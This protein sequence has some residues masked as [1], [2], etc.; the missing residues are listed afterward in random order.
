VRRLLA[1]SALGTLLV[2]LLGAP[3]S[4]HTSLVSSVPAAGAQVAGSPDAVVL[5]FDAEVRPELSKVVVT[6]PGGVDLAGGEP[7]VDG[8][9]VR[10][11]LT[12]PLGSGRWTVA[13]RVIAADGHP[14]TG[15]VDFA[16]T[17]TPAPGAPDVGSPTPAAEGAERAEGDEPAGTAAPEAG[18]EPVEAGGG[19]APVVLLGAGAVALAGGLAVGQRRRRPGGRAGG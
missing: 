3:A 11:S 8:A 16:V 14:V 4:A 18:A 13:Y 2:L 10:Q 17:D 1:V 5:L 19:A 15:T 9:T 6:G 12:G 7:Q